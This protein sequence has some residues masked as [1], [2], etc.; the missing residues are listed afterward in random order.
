LLYIKGLRGVWK[1]AALARFGAVHFPAE[2]EKNNEIFLL[3]YEG[4]A[5]ERSLY[6]YQLTI[7]LNNPYHK[8]V[9]GC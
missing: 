7:R 5:F 2:A 1:E 4:I 9:Q 3:R 8:N 6:L